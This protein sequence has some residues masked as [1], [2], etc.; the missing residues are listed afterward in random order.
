MR[1]ASFRYFSIDF[2]SWS[3]DANSPANFMRVNDYLSKTNTTVRD[4]IRAE[5]R[6]GELL[7]DITVK[8]GE[9]HKSHDATYERIPVLSS[10]GINKSQS[11]RWTR[12]L[13]H[14]NF[15]RVRR[16]IWISGNRV[17]AQ[18]VRVVRVWEVRAISKGQ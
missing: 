11:S 10:L 5:R 1:S 7:R 18:L 14:G 8:G 9:R 17:P 4:F 15:G 12:Y 13:S 16:R 6:D 3:D 2:C